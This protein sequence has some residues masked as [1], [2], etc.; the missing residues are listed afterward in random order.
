MNLILDQ[1]KQ[2]AI[3][4]LGE[5]MALPFSAYHDADVYAEECAKV[6]A[7]E[8]VFICAAL[9]IARPGDYCAVTI[10]SEPVVILRGRDGRPRAMS[11]VCRHRGTLLLDEGFGQIE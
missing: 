7:N 10:G 8:W 3:K 11:N 4:P 1:L 9:E 5:A 2:E 6:F